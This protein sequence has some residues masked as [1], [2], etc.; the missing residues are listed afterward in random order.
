MPSVPVYTITMPTPYAVGPVNA[1]LIEAEP[2]TLIDAGINTPQAQNAMLVALA[3]AGYFPESIERVL[4][5]HAHPDHY[6]LLH[7]LQERSGATV[8]FPEREIARVRD[9][10]MLFEV[11]RL[12]LEAGMPIDLL[13]KMD[14]QRREGPRS[15]LK[16]DEVVAVT[17][18]DT[19]AFMDDDGREFELEAHLMPGHTGGHVVYLEPESRTLFAGD[20]LLPET[21]PNPLL[22]AS[23]D[24][25]GERRRSLKEY[26]R[27]LERMDE[28]GLKLVYPGHG[29][30]VSD[31]GALIT[32]TIEHHH[33]R[34]AVVASFL[35]PEGKTPYEVA[36]EVF[37]N[38]EGYDSF[39]AVSEVV[40]HLDLV[41][42]DGDAVVEARE[43]V[44]Y[45]SAA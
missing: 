14:Q 8:F 1:Y 6:G 31:P 7:M 15:K 38:V 30:V 17:H 28:M 2:L 33:K 26:M 5:T 36:C 19:F 34:K 32:S 3:A 4:I 25:P 9:S 20:Q 23:L 37:P 22:E 12:L 13:F 45:Y 16:H 40:A 18:G 44:T 42:E 29:G 11:G 41:V 27:S 21:S 10:Q 24:E 39:L 43:G 35:G